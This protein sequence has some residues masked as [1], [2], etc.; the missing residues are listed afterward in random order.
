MEIN[1]QEARNGTKWF[2]GAG[3]VA[4]LLSYA[5]FSADE[6]L[7]HSPREKILG[8]TLKELRTAQSS[9]GSPKLVDPRLDNAQP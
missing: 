4:L 2:Y 1:A 5:L 7:S 8:E 3:L 6:M 9:L